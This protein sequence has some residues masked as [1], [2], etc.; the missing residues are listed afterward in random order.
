LPLTVI[1]SQVLGEGAAR[2]LHLLRWRRVK[3][4]ASDQR[5]TDGGWLNWRPPHDVWVR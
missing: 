3:L 5:P 4:M 1:G 2:L